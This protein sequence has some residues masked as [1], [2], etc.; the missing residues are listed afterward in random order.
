MLIAVFGSAGERDREKREVQGRIAGRYCDLT[1][2]TDEDPRD[3][4]PQ[5]IL[6]A[7]AAGVRSTGRREGDGL[8]VIADRSLAVREALRRATP[9]DVVLLLGKGHE[10]SI[11]YEH[12][13]KVA[14]SERGEAEQALRELGY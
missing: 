4:D 9:G 13:R 1:I 10:S 11:L 7:I 12:G 6:Q 2:V 8:L 14:W 5:A 3:E